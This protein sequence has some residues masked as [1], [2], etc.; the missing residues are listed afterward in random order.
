[1][2]PVRILHVEDDP[3]DAFFFRRA[4]KNVKPECELHVVNDG[5]SAMNYLLS[6]AVES[7]TGAHPMPDLMV[8]DLK[9]NGSSGFEILSWTR[10]QDGLKSLPIVILSGS[11]LAEDQRKACD[12]GAS[13]FIVKHSDYDQIAEQVVR[14]I[15]KNRLCVS[16]DTDT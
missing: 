3:D 2:S 9:L 15:S 13:D 11:S 8:L 5:E 10:A 16:G 12:L 4:I 6:A 7:N 1:M 14:F